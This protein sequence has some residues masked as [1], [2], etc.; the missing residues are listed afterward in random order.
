MR[1]ILFLFV[2]SMFSC[3]NSPSTIHASSVEI[4][5][6]AILECLNNETE[7]AFSRDYK[8]WKEFWVQSTFVTKTYIDNRDSSFVEMLGWNEIDKFVKTYI[9]EHPVPEPVTEL[10]SNIDV[11]LYESGAWVSYSQLNINN[12]M[13]RETR[14]MEKVDGKW[15]IAGMHTTIYAA[16]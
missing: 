2:F 9:E 16:K 6:S 3:L 13:K 15:R 14:L 7:A 8:K 5:K 12:E 10:L 1:V 11:R 4:E